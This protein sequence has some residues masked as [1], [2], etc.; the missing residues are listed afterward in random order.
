MKKTERYVE[1]IEKIIAA[2]QQGKIEWKRDEG[3][4]SYSFYSQS[5]NEKRNKIVVDKSLRDSG[6]ELL[7]LEI[8]DEEQEKI[9]ILLC[10]DDEAFRDLIYKVY[11]E[12]ENCVEQ[13]E[14]AFLEDVVKGFV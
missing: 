7:F 9:N 10:A 11:D 14:I 6:E 5:S 2:T 3:E 12:A 13:K 8:Y 4:W 1:F